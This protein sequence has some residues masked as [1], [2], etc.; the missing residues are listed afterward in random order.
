[1]TSTAASS[2]LE[3]FRNYRQGIL[4]GRPRSPKP[5]EFFTSIDEKL[6][7][8]AATAPR[9]QPSDRDVLNLL[10]KRAKVLHLGLANY[11]WFTD[12]SRALCLRLAGTPTADRP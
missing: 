1:M 6:D 7:P 9:T 2:R 4:P 3:E 11:C 12:P 10:T 8:A 5:T